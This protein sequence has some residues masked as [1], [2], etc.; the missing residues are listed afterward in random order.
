M[1]NLVDDIEHGKY[2]YAQTT[3]EKDIQR[4]RGKYSRNEWTDRE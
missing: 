3:R 2:K 4:N 1:V